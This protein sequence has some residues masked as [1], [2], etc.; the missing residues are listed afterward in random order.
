MS[1]GGT[2]L[3]PTP[4]CLPG[5]QL[6]TY[7]R[8]RSWLLRESDKVTDFLLRSLVPDDTIQQRPRLFA[9]LRSTLSGE[10]AA[11]YIGSTCSS[12]LCLA[13]LTY[14]LLSALLQL[15]LS[16][17]TTTDSSVL[18]YDRLSATLHSAWQDF[19]LLHISFVSNALLC[20]AVLHIIP[21][22]YQPFCMSGKT[23]ASSLLWSSL[24]G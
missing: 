2:S 12:L 21:L 16:G 24:S 6:T 22:D 3:R 14:K 18:H 10:T 9:T 15:T 20:V 1:A 19:G 7:S 4:L 8:Y 11:D 5:R 23:T 13:V 17:E